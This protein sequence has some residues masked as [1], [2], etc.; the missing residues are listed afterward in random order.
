MHITCYFRHL[1]SH[2]RAEWVNRKRV[3]TSFNWL[4]QLVTP[5]V[6]LR[7]AIGQNTKALSCIMVCISPSDILFIHSSTEMTTQKLFIH[8]IIIAIAK[9][10]PTFLDSSARIGS[11]RNWSPVDSP[12][13]SSDTASGA[14]IH[15]CTIVLEK[16]INV[17]WQILAKLQNV[18]KNSKPRSLC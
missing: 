16:P 12:T 6:V 1:L 11:L 17:E 8:F 2:C 9:L 10:S 4:F 14:Y 3:S 18:G 7:Y 13:L 15:P 5:S